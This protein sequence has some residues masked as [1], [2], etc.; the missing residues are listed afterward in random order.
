MQLLDDTTP[1]G[2]ARLHYFLIN[3][4]PWSRLDHNAPFVPGVPAKPRRGEL[5]SRGRD[6]GRGRGLDEVAARGRAG[7]GARASSPPS[8]GAATAR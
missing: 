5:L 2:R 1:L 3:K 7:G 8:G 4:G 6:Q